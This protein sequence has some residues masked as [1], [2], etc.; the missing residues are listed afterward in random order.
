MSLPR[1]I[2]KNVGDFDFESRPDLGDNRDDAVWCNKTTE[3][4]LLLG[5][6]MMA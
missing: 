3:A 2:Q 4:S 5:E 1:L 6:E